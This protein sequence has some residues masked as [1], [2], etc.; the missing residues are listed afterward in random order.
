MFV[1][2]CVRKAGWGA[3]WAGCPSTVA[4]HSAHVVAGWVMSPGT[5]GLAGWKSQ[6][7]LKPSQVMKSCVVNFAQRE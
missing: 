1:W 6:S 3:L 7:F 2:L 5:V 4:S